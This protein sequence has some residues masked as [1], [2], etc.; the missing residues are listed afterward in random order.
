MHVI[1]VKTIQ[2]KDNDYTFIQ[3]TLQNNQKA[4]TLVILDVILKDNYSVL[5]TRSINLKDNYGLLTTR[6]INIIDALYW[7]LKFSKVYRQNVEQD[8]TVS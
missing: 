3:E 6:W 5:T 7:L 2:Y 4:I 8:I 1:M